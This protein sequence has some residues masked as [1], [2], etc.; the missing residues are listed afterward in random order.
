MEYN[1]IVTA[2]R[3]ETKFLQRDLKPFGSFQRTAFRDVLV[4][5]V[6]DLNEFMDKLVESPPL[7][8]ARVIPLKKVFEFKDP[9]SL[10]KLLEKEVLKL[11]F[12]GSFRVTVERRGWK[13]EVN[14]F[15]WAKQLGGLVHDKTGATVNLKNS[16]VEIV[17]EVMDKS[18]GL[19]LITKSDKEKYFF[20]KT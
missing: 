4:G 20:I 9:A 5:L 3:N 11:K 10:L 2:Y 6:T 17:I 14:S 18:C 1:V 8:L 16:E 19:A 15:E 12:S 13:G 7:S